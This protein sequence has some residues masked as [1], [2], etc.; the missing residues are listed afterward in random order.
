MERTLFIIRSIA[1]AA[2]VAVAGL[3]GPVSAQ[4]AQPPTATEAF[5]LRQKCD[6]IAQ[7]WA[8]DLNAIHVSGVSAS[9]EAVSHYSFSRAS[10]YVLITSRE[11]YETN[12]STELTTS[13]NEGQGGNE[14]AHFGTSLR[15]GHTSKGGEV[16]DPSYPGRPE[17]DYTKG[18][19]GAWGSEMYDW[20]EK[21]INTKMA[22]Q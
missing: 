8:A 16:R 7:K 22:E 13:L 10:C 19:L 14:L 2:L 17:P 11:Y 3:A 21:Y 15:G 4:S 12:K 9:H 6:Q 18:G 1:A 5:N 20:A